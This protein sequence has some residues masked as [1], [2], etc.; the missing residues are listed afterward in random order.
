MADVAKTTVIRSC[1]SRAEEHRDR[2]V[3]GSR[4]FNVLTT[5]AVLTMLTS[6]VKVEVLALVTAVV[7][8]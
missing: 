6:I 2:N 1:L 5:L 8:F 7:L 3:A 4:Y